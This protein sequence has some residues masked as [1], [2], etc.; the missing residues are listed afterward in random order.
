MNAIYHKQLGRGQ[1]PADG[2]CGRNK[3]QD[4]QE[5]F[6]YIYEI[7]MDEVNMHRDQRPYDGSN[8]AKTINKVPLMEA[9]SMEWDRYKSG[10]WSTLETVFSHIVLSALNCTNCPYTNR[11]FDPYFSYTLP[12]PREPVRIGLDEMLDDQFS[13]FELLEKSK[14]EDCGK[15][16]GQ[17]VRFAY[18]PDVQIFYFSRFRSSGTISRKINTHI[19]L[20]WDNVDL[21]RKH[22]THDPEVMPT[23]SMDPGLQKPPKYEAYAAVWHRGSQDSGHY[24]ATAR[25]LDSPNRVWRRFDDRNISTSRAKPADLEG[26]GFVLTLIFLNRSTVKP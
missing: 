24:V 4:A 18:L 20:D 13:D 7:I 5:F 6:T 21:G 1:N 23:A 16:I 22:I 14:C 17:I 12:F 8:R 11:N 2:L 9:A 26:L 15:E 25:D 3:Q 10:H 19:D